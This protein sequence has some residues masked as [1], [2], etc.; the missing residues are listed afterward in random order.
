M[1]GNFLSGLTQGLGSGLQFRQEADLN[2]AKME[3]LR[4]EQ[5][6]AILAAQQKEEERKFKMKMDVLDKLPKGSKAWHNLLNS[7]ASD[8]DG[9]IPSGLNVEGGTA[10]QSVLVPSIKEW[11]AGKIDKRTML[12][13]VQMLGLENYAD[14]KEIEALS[15]AVEMRGTGEELA[16]AG[17]I[18]SLMQTQ[19]ELAQG[20]GASEG[21][22]RGL[23]SQNIEGR[24]QLKAMPVAK[25]EKPFTVEQQY[26]QKLSERIA[27]GEL[28]IEQALAEKQKFKGTKK[29]SEAK[30]A[31]DDKFVGAF[32]KKAGEK[33][34]E[35]LSDLQTKA[36]SAENEINI[37]NEALPL[38]ASEDSIYSGPTANVE[39]LF[40]EYMQRVG[41]NVGGKKAAN[42]RAYAAVMGRQVGE[43]IKSFGSG[44]GLSDADR[45]YAT[46][47]AGG[48]I[49]LTK[50]ALLKLIDIN[51]RL[52][53]DRIRLYNREAE[54][55]QS[56][57]AG[58]TAP[59]SKMGIPEVKKSVTGG[60]IRRYNPATRRLE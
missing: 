46:K 44:T 29:T 23:M 28:S 41:W 6:N 53:Q 20:A 45:E 18:G 14:Q 11:E 30:K 56:I 43:I 47:I 1:A 17:A 22:R 54:R 12:G 59:F 4:N 40:D 8:S 55:A 16:Q 2:R 7:I 37:I 9:V 13:R 35:R 60:T 3:A 10:L 25:P 38:I 51:S 36:D 49:K 32:R 34:A 21:M 48:E 42:T 39:A 24:A 5:R 26:D 52:A 15:K 50:P 31:E 57:I 19:P 33:A 27:S 58:K